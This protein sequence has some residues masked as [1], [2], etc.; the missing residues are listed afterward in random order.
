VRAG[1]E[2]RINP[3]KALKPEVRVQVIGKVPD[4]ITVLP[5]GSVEVAPTRDIAVGTYTFQVGTALGERDT[6]T[7]IVDA[8]TDD[9]TRVNP[10]YTLGYVRAGTTGNNQAPRANILR[11]GR[12]T[13]NQPLPV[14]TKF[15]TGFVGAEVDAGGVVKLAA[16]LNA[17]EGSTITVPVELTYPDGTKDETHAEFE[18]IAA[19]YAKLYQPKYQTGRVAEPGKTVTVA[20]TAKELPAYTE[21]TIKDPNM[22]FRGWDVAV[23]LETGEISA[24]APKVNATPLELPIQV[25]YSDA[26]RETITATVGVVKPPTIADDIPD[27]VYSPPT[28]LADGTIEITPMGKLPSGVQLRKSLLAPVP[29]VVDEGSGAVR[30]L[31]SASV[32][33]GSAFELA[34]AMTCPDGSVREIKVPVATNSQAARVPVE[35]P[36]IAVVKG[37]LPVTVQPEGAPEGSTFALGA[38]FNEPGWRVSVNPKTGAVTAALFGDAG[39]SRVTVPVVVTYPDKSQRIVD[40]QATATSGM[41][42]E[43]PV[44]YSPLTLKPGQ[45]DTLVTKTTDATFALLNPVQGLT[46]SIDPATGAITVKALREAMPGERELKVQVTFD[47]TSQVITTAKVTVLSPG[48][49]TTL[50]QDAGPLTVTVPA[51]PS[52]VIRYRLPRPAGATAYPFSLGKVDA[53]GWDVTLDTATGQLIVAAPAQSGAKNARVPLSVTYLDGSVG[54]MTVTFQMDEAVQDARSSGSSKPP[55]WVYLLLAVLGLGGI[56]GAAVYHHPEWIEQLQAQLPGG[57]K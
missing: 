3:T 36:H 29:V 56:A 11:G 12:L 51:E 1:D 13:Q 41:A 34:L 46:T 22:D 33:A 57:R 20:Q 14:G 38:G 4:W 49:K 28:V 52:A 10:A 55:W 35:Y 44:T 45:T 54:E 32:P 47:D 5:D 16:P 30:I 17:K 42:A 21:F 7:V 48:G 53:P 23:N 37:G 6:I 19:E 2:V 39:A 43:A 31:P 9:A 25:T 24:T 15:S 50:A 27:I 8:R 40:V 18:V 26:S